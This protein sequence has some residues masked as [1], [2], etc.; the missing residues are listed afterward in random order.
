MLGHTE[1]KLNLSSSL[2]QYTAMCHA[3]FVVAYRR[4]VPDPTSTGLEI[5]WNCSFQASLRFSG[6]RPPMSAP[7]ES[8]FQGMLVT[9]GNTFS[10]PPL[11]CL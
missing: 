8:V 7:I 10:H 2:H 9:G 11:I 5:P 6:P 1:R 3:V 4:L